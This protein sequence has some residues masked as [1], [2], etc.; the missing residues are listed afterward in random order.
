MSDEQQTQSGRWGLY[1]GLL[2]LLF[3]GYPLSIGPL[4]FFAELGLVDL[5]QP[6]WIVLYRPIAMIVERWPDLH[7]LIL[8][9]LQFWA[10]LAHWWV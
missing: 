2:V 3:I 10:S 9:Y 7:G 4:S 8:E 5:T 6:H 1:L